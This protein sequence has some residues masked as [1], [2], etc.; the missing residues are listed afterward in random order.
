MIHMMNNAKI[1]ELGIGKMKL[2]SLTL[3]LFYM[4]GKV[5][6]GQVNSHYPSHY[7]VAI[8]CY[9]TTWTENTDHPVQTKFID[10]DKK[11][12][13]A[14]IEI[15]REGELIEIQ[16]MHVFYHGKVC[17]ISMTN[18][19]CYCK[20]TSVGDYNTHIAVIDSAS[21]KLLIDYDIPHQITVEFRPLRDSLFILGG[22][23]YIGQ[24]SHEIDDVYTLDNDYKIARLM[25]LN[26]F[27]IKYPQIP[28]PPSIDFTISDNNYFYFVDGHYCVFKNNHE[29]Q[30][31]DSL[32]LESVES[33]N[34]IFAGID[35]FLYVFSIDYEVHIKGGDDKAY[36]QDWITPN[37][38][39]YNIENFELLDSIPLP[40]FKKGDCVG[41]DH[42]VARVIGPYITYYFGEPGDMEIL[43][44]SMLFI[45]DTRTNE[46]TWLRVG[47]R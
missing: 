23:S 44:P 21:K 6:S 31:I 3:I 2:S 11:N 18:T 25:T 19:A 35:S 10:L 9:D 47:W 42:G 29:K 40:D 28:V 34:M 20:N 30:V 12:I 17:L 36:G 5:S 32:I 45:F 39:K 26:E 33:R 46:T 27:S 16:P 22:S 15:A 7:E 14:N 4:F 13:T 38:R 41:G 8:N 37:L 1:I 43:F 24:V